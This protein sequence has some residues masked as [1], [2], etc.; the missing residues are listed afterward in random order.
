LRPIERKPISH[1]PFPKIDSVHG[2]E[3][4]RAAVLIPGERRAKHRPARNEGVKFVGGLRTTTVQSTIVS[5]AKLGAF[6]RVDTPKANP[7]S[8]NFQGI[9]IDDASLSRQFAR[10]RDTGHDEKDHKGETDAHPFSKADPVFRHDTTA[11]HVARQA[12]KLVINQLPYLVAFIIK[13]NFDR[14]CAEANAPSGLDICS[15]YVLFLSSPIVQPVGV[16]QPAYFFRSEINDDGFARGIVSLMQAEGGD[17]RRRASFRKGRSVRA[18]ILSRQQLD[19]PLLG[20]GIVQTHRP[21]Q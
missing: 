3:S 16:L 11:R 14:R 1:Q 9:A 10:H 8:P 13:N 17:R 21:F 19:D 12:F 6:R 18:T 2:T 7:L 4:N 20:A 15:I 5:A